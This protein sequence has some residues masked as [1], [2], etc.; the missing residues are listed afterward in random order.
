MT[1]ADAIT[2]LCQSF[3]NSWFK[4]RSTF[5]ILPTRNMAERLPP[6]LIISYPLVIFYR[7]FVVLPVVGV[8]LAIA[9]I[10]VLGLLVIGGLTILP[11]Y[12]LLVSLFDIAFTDDVRT[13]ASHVPTFYT[14]KTKKENSP[15]LHLFVFASCGVIFGGIQCV[16]WNLTFP[17][18]VEQ[19][20]W[21]IAVVSMTVASLAGIPTFVVRLIMKRDHRKTVS[22][23]RVPWL[24]RVALGVGLYLLALGVV[25]R[26]CLIVQTLV[27]LRQ[28]PESTLRAATVDW[29]TFVPHFL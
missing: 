28:Q 1:L 21:R 4:F 23:S 9:I 22:A 20:F 8:L 18:E 19:I 15:L 11:V 2:P 17:S 27:L 10:L 26:L 12:L 6:H 7:L 24:K 13:D 16:G 14:P 3:A 5:R 29:I 25:A